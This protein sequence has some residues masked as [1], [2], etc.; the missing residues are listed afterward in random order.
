M[1]IGEILSISYAWKK[2]A[3]LVGRPSRL[4]DTP[5]RLEMLSIYFFWVI[6]AQEV[7]PT[8]SER[9]DT[10]F[11]GTGGGLFKDKWAELRTAEK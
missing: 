4:L 6:C 11:L 3:G 2:G 9:G 5:R 8:P 7:L 10:S 1:S